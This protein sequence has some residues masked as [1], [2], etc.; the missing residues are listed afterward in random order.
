MG[1]DQALN[2]FKDRIAPGRRSYI[3]INR[4]RRP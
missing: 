2:L 4:Y 3:G 1:L